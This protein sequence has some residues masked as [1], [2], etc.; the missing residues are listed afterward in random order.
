MRKREAG[1]GGALI[2]VVLAFIA[3]LI[4]AFVSLNRTSSGSAE[5]EQTTAKLAIAA[6]ALESFASAAFR[7]PCPA[8]PNPA[9]PLADGVEMRKLPDGLTCLFPEGTIPWNTIGMR[10]EDSFDAWGRRISYRVF[11]GD[12]GAGF[13]GSVTQDGGAS[14]ANCDI[15]EASV[16]NTSPVMADGSG[17][18]CL[19]FPNNADPSARTTRVGTFLALKRLKVTDFNVPYNDV[20]YV[21]ISHGITG[22]GGYTASG[23]LDLPPNGD[24]L[25]NTRAT[26]PF[27][28][29]AFSDPDTGATAAANAHFDDLILYRRIEDLAKRANLAARNWPDTILSAVVFDRATVKGALGGTNPGSDT[30]RSTIAFNNAT[31]SAFDSSGRWNRRGQRRRRPPVQRGSREFAARFSRGRPPVR[32]YARQV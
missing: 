17:G 23:R 24:E 25:D 27:V 14:M 13:G 21:L 4:V 11:T 18:L 12:P 26:G 9:D 2:A 22:L 28:N 32:L 5:R 20:A 19:P 30:G 8:N 10:R 7:L 15:Y 16:G 3:L 29:R 6:T 1:A 31:V